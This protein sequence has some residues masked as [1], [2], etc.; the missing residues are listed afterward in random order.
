[1]IF[2]FSNPT[3][4]EGAFYDA[5]FG[6]DRAHWVS[7]RVDARE[8]KISNKALLRNHGVYLIDV[9]AE[10]LLGA[11]HTDGAGYRWTGMLAMGIPN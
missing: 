1:M 6:K 8:S 5:V 4:R 2:L 9:R 11:C 7:M 10:K 3:R